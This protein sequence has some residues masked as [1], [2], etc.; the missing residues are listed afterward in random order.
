MSQIPEQ[1]Q[2]QTVLGR[3]PARELGATD[4]HTLLVRLGGPLVDSSRDFLLD[5]G[6]KGVAE[7]ERFRAAGG[8]AVVDMTPSVPGRATGLRAG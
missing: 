5:Q 8:A 1:W 7:L 4:V 6:D 3:I 2:V